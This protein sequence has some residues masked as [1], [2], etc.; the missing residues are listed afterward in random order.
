MKER[1]DCP[2]CF[3]QFDDLF[4]PK[5]VPLQANEEEDLDVPLD[6][7]E[8]V[9]LLA[10]SS[11]SDKT[12][13]VDTHGHAQLERDRDETYDTSSIEKNDTK[14]Q[15]K[16][17]ACAVEPADWNATLTYSSK[18][19]SILPALGVHPWYL[20]GLEDDWIE[21][22]EKLLLL[23]PS[24]LV[25][26]IGLCKMARWVRQH[27]EGKSVALV[28]Q[29]DVFK[30]QM[31]LAARLR[32]P[33]SVHCVNQHGVFLSVMN[34]LFEEMGEQENCEAFP[35][36]IAMHSF[37]GTAHHVKELLNLEKRLSPDRPLFYFGFSHAVN[38]A[39]CTSVKSR[40]KGKDAVAAVPL[41]RLLVE[42]DVH[43]SQDLLGGTTG[44]ISYVSWATG[45][46]IADVANITTRNG[47]TFLM[48]FNSN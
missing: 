5:S 40:R 23:H 7:K 18:S 32:R 36:A 39:M 28:I 3:F 12:V 34:E 38:F 33:V 20:E 15:L 35:T 16:A 11:S 17:I 14:I 48:S 26:E 1:K 24:A 43:A 42:S 37:T 30:K 44:A 29:R 4:L 21:K 31:K 22:L 6:P 19:D 2:C 41:D 27:P 8:A 45:T 46:D 13:I 25:G 10:N 47:L 9:T